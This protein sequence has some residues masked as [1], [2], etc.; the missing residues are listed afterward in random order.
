VTKRQTFLDKYKNKI[1]MGFIKY[2]I[3]GYLL[4]ETQLGFIDKTKKENV[5]RKMKRRLKKWY[6]K[7]WKDLW[8]LFR[9][10]MS[11]IL[12]PYKELK[13]LV[14]KSQGEIDLDSVHRVYR[15]KQK[16]KP[17]Y[18]NLFHTLLILKGYFKFTLGSPHWQLIANIL[19]PYYTYDY[20]DL[21]SLWQ[22][23]KKNYLEKYGIKINEVEY[24]KMIYEQY[25]SLKP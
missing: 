19:E 25:L 21:E 17:R 12:R 10:S 20:S 14:L 6:P 16:G 4:R 7:K 11:E 9:K 2:V 3:D 18:D 15:P 5:Y 8:L 24:A 1:N 23:M 22:H 13:D